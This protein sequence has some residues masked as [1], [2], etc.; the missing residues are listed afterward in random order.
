V[1]GEK[2]GLTPDSSKT[3]PD[4]G[5]GGDGERE[6]ITIHNI[7]PFDIGNKRR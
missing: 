7:H 2:P 5:R 6:K 3:A 4:R 1:W